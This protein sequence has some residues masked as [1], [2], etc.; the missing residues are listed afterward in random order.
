MPSFL[1]FDA[2][3]AERQPQMV[4]LRVFGE[5]VVIPRAIPASVVLM[6]LREDE[7]APIPTSVLMDAGKAVFGKRL[8][9]WLQR[10]DFSLDMLAELLKTTFELINGAP[11]QKAVTEDD[12][13]APRPN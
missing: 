8:V 12:C 6:L 5:D 1:D 13:E 4:T 9:A 7:A 2:M 10:T 11:G 3:M